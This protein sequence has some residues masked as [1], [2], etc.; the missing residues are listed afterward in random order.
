MRETPRS[1]GG[2]GRRNQ[3]IWASV[4]KGCEWIPRFRHERGLAPML[5]TKDR[6]AQRT[7]DTRA[8][9]PPIVHRMAWGG[10]GSHLENCTQESFAEFTEF[11][12]RCCQRGRQWFTSLRSRS[13]GFISFSGSK[14]T[15]AFAKL[16]MVDILSE[17][18]ATNLSVLDIQTVTSPIARHGHFCHALTV[19][20]EFRLCLAPDRASV[21]SRYTFPD[22]L[23]SALSPVYSFQGVDQG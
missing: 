16:L 8:G 15:M 20:C 13:N 2:S 11:V 12:T 23:G 4:G 14:S 6:D 10:V 18:P 17:S 19:T 22:G 3:A 1:G 21:S 7:T 5:R 9:W